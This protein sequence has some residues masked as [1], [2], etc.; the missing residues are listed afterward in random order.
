MNV[1]IRPTHLQNQ[2]KADG[3]PMRRG[4]MVRSLDDLDVDDDAL[5]VEC[6]A[7][8]TAWV[9]EP[10]SSAAYDFEPA[11]HSHPDHKVEWPVP[12]ERYLRG[13]EWVVDHENGVER[14][15]YNSKSQA[16]N[17][18][19]SIEMFPWCFFESDHTE[20][21]LR[22]VD[23]GLPPLRG[24]YISED[25]IDG[26]KLNRLG[27]KVARAVFDL[28]PRTVTHIELDAMP[29]FETTDPERSRLQLEPLDGGVLGTVVGEHALGKTDGIDL[30]GPD[31][32]VGLAERA[33]HPFLPAG[34]VH[35]SYRRVR[36]ERVVGGVES[37]VD[38]LPFDGLVELCEVVATR[39]DADPDHPDV[40][41]ARERAEPAEL[42]RE[43]VD[44]AL[45]DRG[46]EGVDEVRNA[47][48][49]DLAEELQ[50]DVN[51]VGVREAD[52]ARVREGVLYGGDRLLEAVETDA[53]EQ[54][55]GVRNRP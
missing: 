47:R 22:E 25:D 20:P 16:E 19:A 10:H 4:G 17:A 35:S 45:P 8:D 49:V 30:A 52:P 9:F 7:C 29:G 54:S 14:D 51:V 1:V 15:T 34:V 55:H 46:F 3:G 11:E 40:L 41:G 48:S 21:W 23:P 24:Y 2:H 13:H 12:A 39:A 42:G 43:R 27:R 6:M 26:D 50:R 18:I 32:R 38:R 36:R 31:G 53:D 33:L 5:I 37:Q 44:V 28:T